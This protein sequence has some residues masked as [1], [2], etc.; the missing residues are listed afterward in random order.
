MDYSTRIFIILVISIQISH[1]YSQSI[2]QT[3]LENNRKTLIRDITDDDEIFCNSWKFTVETNDAGIWSRIPKRCVKFVG[4]YMLGIRYASDSDRVL[5]S[6]LSFARNVKI[7]G[8]GKD[9]WVFDIDETLLSNVPYYQLHG[10]GSGLFDEKSFDEW[11]DLAE[12]PA[13]P[14]S[15]KLFYE[16]K[17]LGFKIILLTGRSE[18]QRGAT[19]K[20]LLFAG[21]DDWE[22][23]C[24]RDDSDIGKNATLYKSGRRQLAEEEGYRIHGNSGDQWSD[25][26]G[27]ARATRS[28]KLPNPMYYIA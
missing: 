11:V 3:P 12:A 22:K 23:L 2:I 17:H 19:E 14:A 7:A 16:L 5:D 9:A 27:F 20:N 18:F 26:L 24:L 4:D 10:F 13:L 25:L 28:F 21:Y 8:D 6:S 1:I 15:L